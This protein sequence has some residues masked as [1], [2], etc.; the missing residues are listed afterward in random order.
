MISLVCIIEDIAKELSIKYEIKEEAD[1]I[2]I[3]YNKEDKLDTFCTFIDKIKVITNIE[4]LLEIFN[5]PIDW[6]YFNKHWKEMKEKNK[7]FNKKLENIRK[8]DI[9]NLF[10]E[11]D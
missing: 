2:R 6:D 5:K 8:K 11:I 7:E 3:W 10:K 4:K 9:F 1:V